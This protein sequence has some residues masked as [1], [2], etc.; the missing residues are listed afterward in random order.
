MGEVVAG[1][2]DYIYLTDD[3]T[4]T[5]NG[6]SIR[7][8]VRE[9]ILKANGADKFIEIADRLEAIRRALK[10]AQ[11]GDIVVLTGIGHENYRNQGG[12]KIPW[13]ERDVARQILRE[14]YTVK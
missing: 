14:I 9:G 3:E 11:E 10:E 5:E 6:D 4:Y 1:L 13:D 8:S 12:K 2:A 7:A